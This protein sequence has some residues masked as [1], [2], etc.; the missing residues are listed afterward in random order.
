MDRF[1][2]L[3]T[4]VTVV[5]SGQIS[6]AA[7]RLGCAKSV[8][9]RR[10]SEL[11][12]RLGAQLLRR[13]TRSLSTTDAGRDFHGRAVRLLAELE[14]AEQSVSSGQTSLSGRLRLAAPL[15]FGLLHLVPA[16]NVFL[17]EHPDLVLDL[18]LND[19]R[20]DLIDEGVDLALRIGRLDDSSL[21]ARKI[22]PIRILLGASPGY[23]VRHGT[24]ETPEELA[25]HRG[26]IYGNMENPNLW[27]FTDADGAR[28]TVRVPIRLQANNG[29]VLLEAAAAGLGI[30]M[31][32]TFLAYRAVIEG[33]VVPVL[34]GFQLEE[35]A[36]YL[37]YP[38]RRF[39]PQRV[40]ALIDFLLDRF[41]QRP[42]WDRGLE[43]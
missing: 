30:C 34:S 26:L 39:V 32:P 5:E 2:A 18:D 9:S 43:V 27:R 6:A 12:S 8:V 28:R 17:A 38:S 3:R 4:F 22:A 11:E 31:T 40:K 29:D 36:A 37:L 15:S 1:E 20:T 33:R 41:G 10:I 7:E 19:R 23:L 14:E 13:T 16:L 42:Y 24:P 21:V 25:G 35:A